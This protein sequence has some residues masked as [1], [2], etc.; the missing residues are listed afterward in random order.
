MYFLVD[1]LMQ[2]IPILPRDFEGPAVAN[3]DG[4]VCPFAGS[5]VIVGREGPDSAQFEG[6]P[7][8]RDEVLHEVSVCQFSLD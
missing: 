5:R 1:F 3:I 8:D 7:L 2:V 4:I 6:M